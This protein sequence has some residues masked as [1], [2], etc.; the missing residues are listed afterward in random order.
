MRKYALNI[1]T[2]PATATLQETLALSIPVP[3]APVSPGARIIKYYP[4]D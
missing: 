3:S 1:S 2:N 4:P